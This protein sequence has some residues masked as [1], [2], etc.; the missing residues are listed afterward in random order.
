MKELSIREKQQ[1]LDI[2]YNVN[3][4]TEIGKIIKDKFYELYR[5]KLTKIDVIGGRGKHHDLLVYSIKIK[6]YVDDKIR[7]KLTK[8]KRRCEVKGC[9]N[10]NA[11]FTD[12]PWE[13][14]VQF[15]NGPYNQ[16]DIC[17]K[18]A[19]C[20]YNNYILTRRLTEKYNLESEIPSLE[21][22]LKN[23]ASVCR[24]PKTSYGL[25]LKRKHREIPGNDKQKTRSLNKEKV[26]LRP[27]FLK[28][29]TKDDLELLKQ[30]VQPLVDKT[31]KEKEVWLQIYGDLNGEY[32]IKWSKQ[33]EIPKIKNVELIEKKSTDILFKFICD[34]NFTFTSILRWGKGA[35]FS[36]L[37]SL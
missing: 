18:Y 17:R 25:E 29:I 37:A 16:F 2:E 28:E 33:Y 7:Y 35:G 24:D 32:K 36:D 30:Q 22:W 3:N 15:Y 13:T 9:K 21:E 23:D 6:K 5:E 20:W 26:E 19:T 14:A 12:K 8:K 34:S 10:V 11:N 4:N 1:L 31:M 27:I